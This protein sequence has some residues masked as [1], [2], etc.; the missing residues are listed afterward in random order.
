MKH[1]CK[2]KLNVLGKP[3]LGK[4]KSFCI[5]YKEENKR[6]EREHKTLGFLTSFTDDRALRSSVNSFG[7]I[8]HTALGYSSSQTMTVTIGR[9]ILR[10]VLGTTSK[11]V[12]NDS[13]P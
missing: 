4:R 8:D 5:R 1:G 2:T 11:L 10:K 9:H 12:G 3:S 7:S 13:L 6:W